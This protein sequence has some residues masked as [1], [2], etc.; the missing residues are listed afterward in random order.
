MR[1]REIQIAAILG[2]FDGNR[3]RAA[4]YCKLMAETYPKL[5]DEYMMYKQTI[6]MEGED[7]N[8]IP[9]TAQLA[10]TAG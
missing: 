3:L 1:S 6:E 9:D 10:H 7:A 5:W 2:R 8:R 4:A